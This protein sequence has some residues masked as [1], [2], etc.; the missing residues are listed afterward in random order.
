MESV[1]CKNT[2]EKIKKYSL[3]VLIVLTSIALIYTVLRYQNGHN[4]VIIEDTI[5]EKIEK[6]VELATVKYNYTD[7]VNFRDSLKIVGVDL[8][9][10]E[11]GFVIKYSGYLKAGV[12]L[13]TI[14]AD[15]KNED[16]V[17][18]SMNKAIIL[19]NVINEEDVV[20]FNERDGLFNKLNFKELYAVLVG[21]KEKVKKE[22]L[23]SGLLLEAEN[24]AKEILISLLKEMKFKNIIIKFK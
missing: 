7:V 10:A 20:F 8:P 2:W 12:N 18:I 4:K 21:Q 15:I 3:I 1:Q 11:K 13:E 24:N 9:F 6:I 17:E 14:E 19:E 16:T 5:E 22:A 23:D